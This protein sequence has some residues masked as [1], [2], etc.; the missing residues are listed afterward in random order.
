MSRQARWLCG[1]KG[2]TFFVQDG[3]EELDMMFPLVKELEA[4]STS[5]GMLIRVRIGQA[6]EGDR[7]VSAHSGSRSEFGFGGSESSRCARKLEPLGECRRGR[8]YR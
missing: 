1:S 4:G 5:G 6:R 7:S 3:E 8:K 2:L